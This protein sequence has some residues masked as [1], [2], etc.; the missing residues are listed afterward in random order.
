MSKVWLVWHV[1][2]GGAISFSRV[3]ER[4]ES[5]DDGDNDWVVMRGEGFVSEVYSEWDFLFRGWSVGA[6]V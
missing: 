4:I 5:V 6:R 3:H 2:N 1:R